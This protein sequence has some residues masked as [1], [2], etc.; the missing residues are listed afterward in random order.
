MDEI[1]AGEMHDMNEKLFR[2]TL[3]AVRLKTGPFRQFKEGLDIELGQVNV[4]VGPNGSGKS[5]LVRLARFWR[6][7]YKQN[8]MHSIPEELVL[9]H[10]LFTAKGE[11]LTFEIHFANEY[12]RL[13]RHR[14]TYR[15]ES[16]GNWECSQFALDFCRP[17]EGWMRSLE[18]NRTTKHPFFN[19][20]SYI[21]SVEDIVRNEYREEFTSR[22]KSIAL[23]RQGP[24]K[25]QLTDIE[26]MARREEPEFI[27]WPEGSPSIEAS[28]YCFCMLLSAAAAK[29]EAMKKSESGPSFGLTGEE[30]APLSELILFTDMFNELCGD[31]ESWSK[32]TMSMLQKLGFVNISVPDRFALS[33]DE[34]KNFTAAFDTIDLIKQNKI[35]KWM[36]AVKEE[37]AKLDHKIR[38][39]LNP[40]F[41]DEYLWSRDSVLEKLLN[42]HPLSTLSVPS[43]F[44]DRSTSSLNSVVIQKIWD[45]ELAGYGIEHDSETGSHIV[46][47]TRF[48]A[49]YKKRSEHSLE[50]LEVPSDL[51]E[52]SVVF[53]DYV[54]KQCIELTLGE[55]PLSQL[56]YGEQRGLFMEWIL[57]FDTLTMLTEPEVGLHPRFQSLLAKI[58]VKGLFN[59]RGRKWTSL[60]A[61]P[62]VPVEFE[63]DEDLSREGEDV[64]PPQWVRGL[65]WRRNS[66]MTFIETHSEYLIRSLQLSV[67]QTFKAEPQLST[68]PIRGI[69]VFYIDMDRNRVST[70]KDMKLRHDGMLSER[71]GTGFFDESARLT[72]DLLQQNEGAN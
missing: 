23:Y 9:K 55:I 66:P 20:I 40:I 47:K 60:N 61:E 24:A 48:K 63:P 16:N 13:F 12:A 28:F 29:L 52:S 11:E 50:T 18:Y 10:A 15:V 25:F 67:G 54:D 31:A 62:L 64:V 56:S 71:F 38:A 17:K 69:K 2:P 5:T 1:I 3:G 70:V 58:I 39:C 34:S 6:E 27:L 21:E 37:V 4:F 7:V 68:Q 8:V 42:I 19:M 44:I 32:E 45:V 14:L 72:M 22:H 26:R 53:E 33:A 59:D 43:R 46:Y 57:K 41:L 35:D 51:L 36:S 49:D 30:G 65:T